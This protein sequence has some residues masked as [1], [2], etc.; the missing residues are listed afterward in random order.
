M[1]RTDPVSHFECLLLRLKCRIPIICRR[2]AVRILVCDAKNGCLM[3]GVSILEN[4]QRIQFFN[5]NGMLLCHFKNTFDLFTKTTAF[6][7]FCLCLPFE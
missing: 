2:T 3:F 6:A 1:L 7:L 5:S 4:D